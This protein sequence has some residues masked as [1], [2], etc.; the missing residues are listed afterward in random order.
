MAGSDN[1]GH[2]F[3]TL[4]EIL[5]QPE[6]WRQ[7]FSELERSGILEQILEETKPRKEWLFVGCGSSY[8]LAE[9]AASS[10][11]MMT[12][13][14]AR[15]LPASELLLFPRQAMRAAETSQAVV[16][17]RSGKTSEA[18]KAAHGLSQDFRVPTLGITCAADSPLEKACDRTIRLLTADEKSMVMTRSVTS[19]LLALQF[20]A[21]K[22]AQGTDFPFII[23]RLTNHFAPRI[24]SLAAQVEAFV[25]ARSFADY[26]FLGQGPFHAL[27]R[28]ASLKATEMSCSYSQPFH[29][30][31]FRH[32]PKAIVSPETCLTFFLSESGLQAEAEVLAEMHELGGVTIA[33]CNRANESIRR[34]SD[35]LFELE[36]DGPELA[37][38]APFIVPAQLLGFFTGVKKNLNPD[39]PKNLSRVVILD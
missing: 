31:E 38:L 9:A 6:T 18:V 16:I 25:A 26:I 10:W 7:T 3:H 12:G 15:T 4:T 2:S 20:L 24:L 29:T 5:S 11:I 33:I 35:L 39:A 14:P 1:K 37:T 8:Y 17:S 28:E 13:Q 22:R 21:S 36:F 27:A 34:S 30:L 32:G 19:M 23:H